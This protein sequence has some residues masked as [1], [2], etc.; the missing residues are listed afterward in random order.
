VV[1]ALGVAGHP[2]ATVSPHDPWADVPAAAPARPAPVGVGVAEARRVALGEI[3]GGLVVQIETGEVGDRAAWKVWIDAPGGMHTVLVDEVTGAV[4]GRGA[5]PVV[6]ANPAAAL[7]VPS[8]RS[9]QKVTSC[10]LG[11]LPGRKR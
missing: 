11:A 3:P 1:A 7:P 5:E 8:A 9:E 6:T 4:A 10:D 2:W